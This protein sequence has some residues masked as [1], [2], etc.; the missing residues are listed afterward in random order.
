MLINQ[1]ES[2]L[3]DTDGNKDLLTVENEYW[4]NLHNAL[5]RLEQNDDFKLVIKEGYFK[6]KAVNG[7]SLLATDYVKKA[8]ARG[9]IMEQLVAISQL[10][11]Y[12]ATIHN[13]GTIPADADDDEE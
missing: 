5:E 10:E 6:D 11:D 12:F 1:A 8:G 9:D 13:L 2:Q 7:V 3:K 4:V